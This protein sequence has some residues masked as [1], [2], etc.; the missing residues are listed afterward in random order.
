MSRSFIA[1]RS[2]VP[3]GGLWFFQLGDD[4]YESPLYEDCIA[5]VDEILRKHGVKMLATEALAEF[6]CPHMPAYFCRGAGPASPVILAR[7]AMKAAAPYVSKPVE[8]LDVISKRLQKCTG[9]L[10]H[11]RDFCLHCH[12]YDTWVCDQFGGR[13]VKLPA[14]DASGCCSCAKTFEAVI[15]SVVYGEDEPVWEGTPDSCWRY[16]L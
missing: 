12:G 6:M 8:T 2:T 5:H 3:P 14:D 7:D 16:G 10:K 11:R 13:R 4:Y 9:C 15:A 1:T